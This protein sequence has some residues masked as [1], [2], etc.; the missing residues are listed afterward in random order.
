MKS[1]I[2]N[3]CWSHGIRGETGCDKCL[4]SPVIEECHWQKTYCLM[5]HSG[6]KRCL[7]KVTRVHAT[8]L[9]KCSCDP[10]IKYELT[11]LEKSNIHNRNE[12]SQFVYKP[13]KTAYEGKTDNELRKEFEEIY[14]KLYKIN[15]VFWKD[16]N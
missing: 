5:K 13:N 2:L 9:S 12:Q 15:E 14:K 10:D 1:I 8:D 11:D 3:D 4:S 7:Q 6:N 16:G